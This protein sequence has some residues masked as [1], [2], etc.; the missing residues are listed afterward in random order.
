[1]AHVL[2]HS[3]AH[4]LSRTLNYPFVAPPPVETVS[5]PA[6]PSLAATSLLAKT[7]Y[8]QLCDTLLDGEDN[9]VD[10]DVGVLDAFSQSLQGY[11]RKRETVCYSVIFNFTISQ[12]V[13]Q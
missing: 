8:L 12:D 10:R 5:T 7:R 3:L 6:A 11:K 9:V 13:K 1:M 4:T 2:T